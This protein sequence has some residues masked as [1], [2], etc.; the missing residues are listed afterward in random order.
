[1]TI[2]G[3][4]FTTIF[5][6]GLVTFYW[7]RVADDD[8][9]YG[10]RWYLSW[11]IK[12]WAIPM[13]IWLLLNVGSTPVMPPLVQVMPQK[14]IPP[15][16]TIIYPTDDDSPDAQPTVIPGVPTYVGYGPIAFV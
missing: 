11:A 10:W 12:G 3:P 5:F 1:M 9:A 2:I 14:V 7:W 8:K 15:P 4:I 13:A 6:L 16:P